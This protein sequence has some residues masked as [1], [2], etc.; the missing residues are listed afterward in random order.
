MINL[1]DVTFAAQRDPIF[2][3]GGHDLD[4]ARV[5]YQ[6]AATLKSAFT[7]GLASFSALPGYTKMYLMRWADDEEPHFPTVTL[8]YQGCKSGNVPPVK[9]DDGQTIQ[10]ISTSVDS[11]SDTYGGTVDNP[12]K[13][14]MDLEYLA[15]QTNYNWY[16]LTAP[17]LSSTYSVARRATNPFNNVIRRK[18]TTPAGAVY[19][20]DIGT[21]TALNNTLTVSHKV[22]EYRV[23]ELVPNALWR[24]SASVNYGLSI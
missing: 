24:C 13:I 15:Q 7:D 12:V 1:G 3:A 16:S 17:P 8:E 6:G 22:Q 9:A 20:L 19:S 23:E 2:S 5:P 21:F 18:F 11:T 4:T 10:N 14:G